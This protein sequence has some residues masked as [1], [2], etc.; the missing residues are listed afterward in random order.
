MECAETMN[1]NETHHSDRRR[2]YQLR[3]KDF[4][5][6]L[7][8]QGLVTLG[9]EEGLSHNGCD[10]EQM[11]SKSN[12][13]FRYFKHTAYFENSLS[14]VHHPSFHFNIRVYKSSWD[15]L[16]LSHCKQGESTTRA[17]NTCPWLNSGNFDPITEI[18]SP[19][20]RSR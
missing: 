3:T 15:L 1:L 13:K 14:I 2:V 18:P 19:I 7:S 11:H 10:S 5:F 16:T 20:E 9:L 6:C 4:H 12:Q 8:L 17:K